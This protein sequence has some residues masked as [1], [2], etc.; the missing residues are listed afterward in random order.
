MGGWSVG[1]GGGRESE[2]VEG[3]DFITRSPTLTD[4]RVCGPG[5]REDL[6]EALLLEEEEEEGSVKTR[7]KKRLS[8]TS[9]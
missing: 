9:K 5:L 6:E 2:R 1:M 7:A 8:E 3:R 4:L